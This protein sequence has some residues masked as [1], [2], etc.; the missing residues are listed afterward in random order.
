MSA[1]R[2]WPGAELGAPDPRADE[3]NPA[4]STCGT[5]KCAGR[6][7]REL[8]REIVHNLR[9]DRDRARELLESTLGQCERFRQRAEKAEADRERI[10]AELRHE[11][12]Q[13][14]VR[15]ER[16]L[17]ALNEANG[18]EAKLREALRRGYDP[19]AKQCVVPEELL[20]ALGVEPDPK[21][22]MRET[23]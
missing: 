16:L 10:C 15:S 6:C 21:D 19:M 14:R 22:A 11:N 4:C 3:L 17:F 9:A 23:D 7:P 12:S 1:E 13:L 20:H 5:Y 8:L 2:N 18:R